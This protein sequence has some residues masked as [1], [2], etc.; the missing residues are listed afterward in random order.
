MNAPNAASSVR[1]DRVVVDGLS[2]G[3]GHERGFRLALE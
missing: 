3:A 1:I 2:L